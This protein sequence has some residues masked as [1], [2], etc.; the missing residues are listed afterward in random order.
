MQ[1]FCR[2]F[3]YKDGDVVGYQKI[4]SLLLPVLYR[5]KCSSSANS[6]KDCEFLDEYGLNLLKEKTIHLTIK[7]STRIQPFGLSQFLFRL[8]FL[9]CY[10]CNLNVKDCPESLKHSFYTTFD[11]NC[12]YYW[13]LIKPISWLEANQ[14]CHDKNLTLFSY[15]SSSQTQSLKMI[16][17]FPK[18]SLILPI[19]IN[20]QII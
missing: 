15:H 5:V 1:V 16:L 14:F 19:G 2:F 12:Y 18:N 10:F 20:F 13:H 8:N 7:C 3:G 11:N 9:K 6:I 17:N 4:Q